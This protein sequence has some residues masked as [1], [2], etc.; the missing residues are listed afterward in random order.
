MLFIIWVNRIL[1]VAKPNFVVMKLLAGGHKKG[2]KGKIYCY[3]IVIKLLLVRW[4]NI[5]KSQNAHKDD[6]KRDSVAEN[7][8]S[9][10]LPWN[11][12]ILLT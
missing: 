4:I 5:T 6:S 3:S 8:L 2:I 10:I 9:Y 12:Q 11:L 1:K 7:K